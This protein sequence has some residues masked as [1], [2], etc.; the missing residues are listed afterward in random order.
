[1]ASF[2][3]H[4]N[5]AVI[6]TGVLVAPLHS[7]GLIDINQSLL[8]LTLGLIGGILPDLD[9]DNSKPIQGVFKMFSIF[10]PLIVLLFTSR[11]MSLVEMMLGWIISTLIIQL[12]LFKIFLN[13]TTHR[14]IFHSIPMGILMGELTIYSF[15]TF[16]DMGIKLSVVSGFFIFYGFLIHLLLDEIFS[17]NVIGLRMKRSFG[18]AFKL[19]DKQNKIGTISLYLLIILFF[20]LIPN[21]HHIYNEIFSAIGAIKL[22]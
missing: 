8:M 17:I 14:G 15:Y 2:E 9:S 1:L 21:N 19:Y 3:Q 20:I 16:F 18:T 6:A 12:I 7:S 10:L 11:G 22:I 4:V 13:L 5:I